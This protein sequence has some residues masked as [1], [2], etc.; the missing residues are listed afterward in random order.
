MLFPIMEL[1]EGIQL[2]E[3]WKD[4]SEADKIDITG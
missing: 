2:N 1:K 3:V 4:M